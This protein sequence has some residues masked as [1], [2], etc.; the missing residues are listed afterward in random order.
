MV[1]LRARSCVVVKKPKFLVLLAAFLLVAWQAPQVAYSSPGGAG[2]TPSSDRG[3]RVFEAYCVGCHGLSG[4]GDG[5][6]AAPLQRDFGVRPTDLTSE[7]YMAR[8]SDEQLKEAVR[9][10]GKAVHRTPYMPAWG[11]TLKDSQ[12]NDLVAYI[13]E[14]QSD[15]YPEQPSFAEVGEELELGRVLY[16]IQCSAC[17]GPKGEGDGPFVQGLTTGTAGVPGL[18]PPNLASYR[19]FRE[20]TD[21]E[22][23]ELIASGLHHSGLEPAESSWWHRQMRA[24]EMEALILYL[25]TLPLS[26]KQGLG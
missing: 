7:N 6:M 22:L 12:V 5:P 19:F 16:S 18:K 4:K 3:M 26:R 24:R 21:A 11:S 10:G 14:L 9:G 20:R 15:N 2:V 23:E 13:R 25:R 1:I 8:K 17:H